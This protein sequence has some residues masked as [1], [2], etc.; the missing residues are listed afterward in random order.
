MM[1][2]KTYMKPPVTTGRF[3]DHLGSGDNTLGVS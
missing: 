2:R 3:C 1:K